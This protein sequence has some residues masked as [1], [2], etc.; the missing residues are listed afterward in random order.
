MKLLSTNKGIMTERLAT[1][2]YALVFFLL[3][4]V[5]FGY[6]FYIQRGELE[7]TVTTKADTVLVPDQLTTFLKSPHPVGGTMAEAMVRK[8]LGAEIDIDTPLSSFLSRLETPE[9]AFV[10]GWNFYLIHGERKIHTIE[11]LVVSQYYE[12][13]H[14]SYSFTLPDTKAVT[15]MFALAEC[16]DPECFQ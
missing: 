6:L 16:P 15:A 13:S 3:V 10:A 8:A 4:L 5:V 1:N 9:Q 2:M 7:L 12:T 14:Y 11:T